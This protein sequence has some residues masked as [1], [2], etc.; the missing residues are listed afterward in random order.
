MKIFA[1]G[2]A[3]KIN[4]RFVEEGKIVKQLFTLGANP[5]NRAI[6]SI[7]D[8]WRIKLKPE[9][10]DSHVEG[11]FFFGAGCAFP[12]KNKMIRDAIANN[13]NTSV[14]E[15]GSDLLAAARGL[16]GHGRGIACILGTGSNSCYCEN[17]EIKENVS[18]LGYVI[19]DEGSGSAL[20]RLFLGACLKNR[21][22][23]GLKEEFLNE[24]NLT[25]SEILDNIYKKPMAN[26]F[27]AS[28]SPFILRNINNP[29]VYNLVYNSF[30]D[31]F[32]YN[33][34]QYDYKNNTAHLTGSV[35]YYYQDIIRKVAEDTGVKTGV[36]TQS[37]MN[38][39]VKYYS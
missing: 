4:W 2:G 9:V 35:A 29:A 24:Y 5:Y 3:T 8:E 37:P 32:N 23:K 14:I 31:F 27:L 28:F 21:L 1:D 25:V 10:G 18:P 33:V 38:G 20:G 39:L 15:V 34:M 16:C 36:I 6:E 11:V 12:D 7:N 30:K 13:I 26:K 19:G 17:G 22:T